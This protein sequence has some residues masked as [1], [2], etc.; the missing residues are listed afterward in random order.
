MYNR[1]L[2]N[3]VFSIRNTKVALKRFRKLT[4]RKPTASGFENLMVGF[5]NRLDVTL[6]LLNIAPTVFWAREMAPLG[7]VRVNG[8]VIRDAHFRL[9]PGDYVELI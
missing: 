8:Q 9:Q 1:R 3:S 2:S 5:G 7:L 6:I 4:R